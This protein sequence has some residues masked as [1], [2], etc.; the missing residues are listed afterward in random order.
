MEELMEMKKIDV[1]CDR[2]E[3]DEICDGEE[4]EMQLLCCVFN[5]LKKLNLINFR[6]KKC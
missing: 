6:K 1:W 3:E 5:N 4:E 2:E